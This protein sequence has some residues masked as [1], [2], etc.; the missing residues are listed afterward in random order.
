MNES[1]NV[2]LDYRRFSYD[3]YF[4]LWK[5][6]QIQ[7][8]KR[9]NTSLRNFYNNSFQDQTLPNTRRMSIEEMRNV[10]RMAELKL[11]SLRD[12]LGR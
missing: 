11:E 10:K 3:S 5:L 7:E 2:N 8:Q 12:N 1:T 4:E 9:K 6:N